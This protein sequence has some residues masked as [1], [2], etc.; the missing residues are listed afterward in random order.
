M[1]Q[2]GLSK[3]ATPVSGILTEKLLLASGFSREPALQRGD[4]HV[5]NIAPI[6]QWDTAPYIWV[7]HPST[8]QV[9]LPPLAPLCSVLPFPGSKC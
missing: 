4:Q 3:A 1:Q 5:I 6:F 7:F 8:Y 2:V 9:T